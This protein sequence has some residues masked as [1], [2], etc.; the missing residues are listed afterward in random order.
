MSDKIIF[1]IKIEVWSDKIFAG[2][3]K[4]PSSYGKNCP[5]DQPIYF[6]I[7]DMNLRQ[8]EDCVSTL[9]K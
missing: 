6:N 4:K 5:V 2:K 1:S 9:S 8:F 3:L 7:S